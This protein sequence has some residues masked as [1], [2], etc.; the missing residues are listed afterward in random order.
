MTLDKLQ[1]I[2]TTAQAGVT[3]VRT[4]TDSDSNTIQFKRDTKV[5]R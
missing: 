4:E 1:Q 5:R 3:G 2:F